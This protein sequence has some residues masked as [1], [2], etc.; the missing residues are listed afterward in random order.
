MN[1]FHMILT[2][3]HIIFNICNIRV[4]EYNINYFPEKVHEENK[5]YEDIKLYN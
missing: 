2:L 5:P 1:L 4:M 3:Y